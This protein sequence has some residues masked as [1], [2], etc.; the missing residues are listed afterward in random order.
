LHDAV[1]IERAGADVVLD[2][3]DAEEDHPS[4]TEPGQLGNLLAEALAGVLHDAG[5]RH[6]LAR[7]VDAFANEQRGDQIGHRDVAL[8][9]EISQRR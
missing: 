3:W 1:R 7:L 5:E 9:D 8:G 2:R 4:H 6:D